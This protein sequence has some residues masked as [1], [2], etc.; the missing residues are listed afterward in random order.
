MYVSYSYEHAED[1]RM[2]FSRCIMLVFAVART[3]SSSAA[4]AAAV[5]VAPTSEV[6]AI[7]VALFV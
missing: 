3:N 7:D 5:T 4:A 6:E 1:A 2:Y